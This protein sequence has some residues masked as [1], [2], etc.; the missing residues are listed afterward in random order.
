MD[1]APMQMNAN[2]CKQLLSGDDSTQRQLTQENS[3]EL[4][5]STELRWDLGIVI[6]ESFKSSNQ[7]VSVARKK[8]GEAYRLRRTV[9]SRNPWVLTQLYWA[10]VKRHLEY[11]I[12][13]WS[14]NPV[15]NQVLLKN[16][17]RIFTRIIHGIRDMPCENQ[18][19][20]L[21]LATHEHRRVQMDLIETFKLPKASA[22]QA[23]FRLC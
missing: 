21:G 6:K 19:K 3:K 13:A 10:I 8:N 2:E 12:Q 17:R 22:T 20:I 18:L 1:C 7:S 15:K 23:N 11:T 9:E 14:P 5:G 4:R 16:V